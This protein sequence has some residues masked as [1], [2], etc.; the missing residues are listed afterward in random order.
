MKHEA[1][2]KNIG[3]LAFFMVIAVS[4]GGL[5]QI[6]RCFPG[7]DQQAGRGHEAAYRPGAGRPRHLY[8]RRL[9]GLPLADD[10]PFRAETERYG[11]YSVAGESVWDHRSCGA[12]NA[13]GRIWHG[14]VAATP[15][16]GTARTCTTRATWCRNRRCR[17]TL[18]G[19]EHARRQGHREEDGGAAHTRHT[20]HRRRHR[21]RP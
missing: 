10:P 11:H 17:P 5:T 15:M 13:P 7:R 16:T 21:R 2:E 6:V 12:P 18:A 1:V 20:V 9:R 3:L 14:S 4:V 19:R 8:P